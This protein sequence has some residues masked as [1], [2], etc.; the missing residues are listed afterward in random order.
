MYTEM[1]E[2]VYQCAFVPFFVIL[3]RELKQLCCMCFMKNSYYTF[4]IQCMCY[5]FY[6]ITRKGEV[7]WN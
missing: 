3:A 7:F 2:K 4:S 5:D 6:L 1:E